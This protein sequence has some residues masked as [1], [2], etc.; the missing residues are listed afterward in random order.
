MEAQSKKSLGKKVVNYLIFLVIII[1]VAYFWQLN[2]KN[3]APQADNQNDQ[4]ITLIFVFDN[5][6]PLQLQYP[7]SIASPENLFAITKKVAEQQNWAFNFERYESMGILVTQIDELKNGQD[8]KYWQYTNNG[9]TPLVSADNFYPQAN[10]T[11]KW[12]FKISDM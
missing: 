2:S 8:Q 11:V 9:L 3:F 4:N 1:I 5:D 7:Y 12:A 6:E 10:D